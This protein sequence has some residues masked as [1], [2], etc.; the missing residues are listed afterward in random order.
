MRARLLRMDL[1]D[2]F[3]CLC[4]H[5]M[6][7]RMDR[8]TSIAGGKICERKEQSFGVVLQIKKVSEPLH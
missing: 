8:V 6:A 7:D 4:D 2:K 1:G 5:K 3:S